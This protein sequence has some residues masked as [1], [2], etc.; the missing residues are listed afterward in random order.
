MSILCKNSIIEKKIFIHRLIDQGI[1]YFSC[2]SRTLLMLFIL[3]VIIFY[4][5]ASFRSLSIVALADGEIVPASDVK[6]V[7]HREGGIIRSIDVKEGDFVKQG[8]VLLRLDPTI[9]NADVAELEQRLYSLYIKETRLLAELEQY[10]TFDFI[11]HYHKL[12]HTDNKGSP[13][14]SLLIENFPATRLQQEQNIFYSRR[15]QLQRQQAVQQQL[16]AQ[17]LFHNEEIAARLSKNIAS[18]T[19]IQEQVNISDHL[20]QESLS[21][22]MSHIDLLRRLAEIKGEIAED[23]AALKRT[24]AMAEESKKRLALLSDVFL[25]GVREA[26]QETQETLHVLEQRLLKNTDSLQRTTVT[27]PV[28][29]VIKSLYVS[30]LGGVISAGA[31]IADIVPLNDELVVEAR[32]A[33]AD[34][35]YVFPQQKVLLRLASAEGL[36]F[37]AVDGIVE[38]LSPDTLVTEEGKAYFRVRIRAPQSYFV[39]NSGEAF[40]WVPGLLVQCQILIGERTIMDYILQPFI[41]PFHLAMRER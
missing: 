18:I 30:T 21:N 40:R 31:V 25:L 29:G 33:I 35:G 26:L 23:K 14:Q 1:G 34:V 7:Q 9:Q 5:W 4:L 41:R 17:H 37:K 27:A 28:T 11:E 19:L 36:R 22:R 15:K 3:T 16:V 13:R 32:L 20:L 12:I 6:L 39:N 38:Q 10:E 8:Q 24:E 2:A